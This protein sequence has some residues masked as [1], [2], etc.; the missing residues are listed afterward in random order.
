MKNRVY[1]RIGFILLLTI[2][3]GGCTLLVGRHLDQEYGPPSP[4]NR[5]TDTPGATTIDYRQDVQPLLESRCIVCHGCYDAPCQLDLSAHE[6]IERGANKDL[7]YNAGRLLAAEPTRL[8]VDAHSPAEWRKKQFYPVL[9]ERVQTK[10][11]NLKGGLMAKMLQLKRQ[12]P[13]PTISPLPPSF[14]FGIERAQYCPTLE[15]FDEFAKT[16]PLWGMPYGLPNLSDRE[17]HTLKTWLEEG[18]RYEARPPLEAG[19][20]ANMTKWETF[21]NGETPKEQLMSRYLYE[22]LFLA[23]LHFEESPGLFFRLVRSGTPP[24]QAITLIATR[25]PY[26]DPNVD[27][28]YYR[29][30]PVQTT[31]LAKTHMPYLLN[32]QRMARYRALFLDPSYEVPT[33]PSY[34]AEASANPFETFAFLPPQSRYRFLLDEAEFTLMNFIK[35]PVCRGQ[36]ALNVI[37]EH[38]WVVFGNPDSPALGQKAKFLEKEQRNLRM[39]SEQQS[40]ATALKNWLEY[41]RLETQYLAG[42]IEYLRQQL[43]S[44]EDI[45]LDLVWDGDGWNENAALTVFRHED[46]ATVVKGFVGD[47]PKT[48]VLLDYPLLERIHYLLVAGYDIY[49]NIGHQLN[50]RLYMDFLRM[51]GELD[52]LILLPERTRVETWTDW[53]RDTSSEIEEFAK[54][55]HE[56]INRQSGIPYRTARHKS[57]LIGMLRERL[58]PILGRSYAIE[59]IG[60]SH[61]RRELERLSRI[62]GMPISWLPQN[63]ILSISGSDHQVVTLIHNNGL[64]NVSH[65]F[66]EQERRRPEEDTLTV[67]EGFLGAYPNALYHVEESQLEDFVGAVESLNSEEEYQT[68]VSRFGVRRTDPGFWKHSDALQIVYH[69]KA[70]IEAGLFDYNRLEN[71]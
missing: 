6:G 38:F 10:E 61:V 34:D 31:I 25:R 52:F 26:D 18:A 70:P 3:V 12:H 19:V 55:Y 13:L 11:A 69:K 28:I 58:A 20:L 21:L 29:L 51:E 1:G 36:V 14:D 35:G 24:G 40:N 5:L 4:E 59:Q 33:L 45:S 16:Q 8:F 37:N 47:E 46:N 62:Q 42:K 56:R 41:S 65:L 60:N 57:E 44:P 27:R 67:V 17:Y 63:A 43:S 71:R 30:E 22:H 48:L 7:V 64:S 2:I 39:P 49:G 15:E 66:F 32:A 23:H 9:N 50:S 68:L 54:V 53:Y